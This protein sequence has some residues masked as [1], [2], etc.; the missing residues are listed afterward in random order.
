METDKSSALRQAIYACKKGGVVSI[1]GVYGGLL[2]KFP[3]G[4]AF[5]K[6]LTLRMGQT[7]V[8]NYFEPIMKLIESG[9][10]DPSRIITHRMP[11]AKAA[12]AY[13][14]FTEKKDGC[15][16]VVLKP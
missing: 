11:L 4:I 3:L 15:I 5:A 9:T 13:D 12:S 1:P 2:D 7:H 10:V 6:G 8:M 14:I 16:K